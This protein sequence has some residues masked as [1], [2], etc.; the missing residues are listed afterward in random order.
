MI[1]K[2]QFLIRARL[3]QATLEAWIA[4][5]WLIPSR[6]ADDLAFTDADIARASLIRDLKETMEVNDPGIG[7]ILSLLDQMH[8]LRRTLTELLAAVPERPGRPVS[9]P[10]DPAG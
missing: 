3:D 1:S 7:V 6:A 8:G 2:Q 4:E 9:G 5:E 10:R